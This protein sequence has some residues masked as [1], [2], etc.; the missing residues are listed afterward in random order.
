V[1]FTVGGKLATSNADKRNEQLQPLPMPYQTSSGAGDL[2]T[3]ITYNKKYWHFALGYLH[4]LNRNENAFLHSRWPGDTEAGAYFESNRLRRGDDLMLRAERSFEKGHRAITLGLL[5]ILRLQ[6]DE[7]LDETN[8]TVP[9]DGSNQLTV[10]LNIGYS[11]ALNENVNL[12][13]RYANPLVWRKSRP[14]GLTRYVVFYGG[15]TFRL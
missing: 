4:T 9:V 6:K 1:I 2:M 8:Q 13:F 10:N 3:G 11:Y 12:R 5:P 7:I 15:V 14:D